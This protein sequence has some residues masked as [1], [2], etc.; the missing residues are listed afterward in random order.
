MVGKNQAAALLFGGDFAIQAADV[1][2]PARPF[3]MPQAAAA[4]VRF[5]VKQHRIAVA[6]ERQAVMCA[7]LIAHKLRHTAERRMLPCVVQ[8]R[9]NHCGQQPDADVQQGCGIPIIGNVVLL[10]DAAYARAP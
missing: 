2:L 10:L 4:P 6:V 1:P 9:P 3:P 5:L 8:V 7:A